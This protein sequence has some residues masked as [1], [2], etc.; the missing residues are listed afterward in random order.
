M[1][2]VNPYK[3]EYVW[4]TLGKFSPDRVKQIVQEISR[5]LGTLLQDHNIENVA[6]AD[7][8]MSPGNPSESDRYSWVSW[9]GWDW[10][11]PDFVETADTRSVPAKWDL[12]SWEQLQSFAQYL[13]MLAEKQGILESSTK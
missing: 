7:C 3:Q 10:V 6:D 4:N 1:I 13:T 11:Q 8:G 5:P 9:A 2:D 12:R